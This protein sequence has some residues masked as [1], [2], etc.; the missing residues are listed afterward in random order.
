MLAGVK[1]ETTIASPASSSTW[2]LSWPGSELAQGAYTSDIVITAND[3]KGKTDS[4][5]Y[6]GDIIVDK[7]SPVI[8]ITGI[9]GN[10]TYQ[11][12]ATPIFS[13]SDS[14][15][16]ASGV[17]STTA[18]LNGAAYTSG[19]KITAGGNKTLVV[20]SKDNAGNQSQQTINF[21]I[22]KIPDV[23]VNSPIQNEIYSEFDSSFI[24]T[25]SVSDE[26]NN[27]LTC[28]YYIDSETTPRDTKTLSETI[29]KKT[30]AFNSI[31]MGSLSEGAHKIKFEIYDGSYTKQSIIDF[32]IDK[33]APVIGTVTIVSNISSISISGSATDNMPE[34]NA[35]PY[36][37]TVGDNSPSQWTA[38]T[39]YTQQSL[40]PGKAYTVKFEARDKV[41]HIASISKNTYTKAEIPR[42]EILIKSSYTL[43]VRTT[44]N[45][46]SS[47][48]YQI[49]TGSKYVTPEGTLTSSP[50]WTSL[51]NK[52]IT[53]TGLNPNTTYTFQARAKNGENVETT[54]SS[55]AS[56]TTLVAPPGSPDNIT[57]TAT[58]TS[59]TVTWDAVADATSYDIELDGAVINNGMLTAYTHSGLNP[60]TQHTYRIR[61]N[62]AGGPGNWSAP[63]TKSTTPNSSYVPLNI[64]TAATSTSVIV[65]WDAAAGATGYDIEVDGIIINNGSSTNYVHNGLISG[66]THSYRVRSINAGGKS[67]WSNE[68]LVTTL[69]GTLEVPTNL[70]AQAGKNQI[71]L[72]WEQIPGVTYEVEADGLY[73]DNGTAAS[74]THTGLTPN[75]HHSYR[76]RSKRSGATSEWSS[77]LTVTTLLD[78]FGTPT[79]LKGEA[80]NTYITLSW[81]PVKDA[82]GYDVEIDGLLIDNG[83]DTSCEHNGLSPSTR[84][85]YRVRA[86]SSETVSDWT[87]ILTLLTYLLPSPINFTC[88]STE[89]S[90][91]TVW[92]AVYGAQGYD[93]LIDSIQMISIDDNTYYEYGGLRPNTQHSF[94][95]RASNQDG[96]SAWTMPLLGATLTKSYGNNVSISGLSRNTSIVIMWNSIEGAISYDLEIDGTIYDGLTETCYFHEGLSPS[97]QYSYRIRAI[98]SAGSGDWSTLLAASTLSYGPVVPTNITLSSTKNSVRITWDN[99]DDAAEYE[100]ELDGNVISAGT[101]TSYLHSGLISNT[102]H[103]YRVRAKNLTDISPWSDVAAISTKSSEQTYTLDCTTDEVFNFI[104]TAQNIENINQSTFTITFSTSQLEMVDL[105][106][107]TSRVDT[108]VGS[109]IGTDIQVIQ[110]S[111]GTIV[112]TKRCDVPAGQSWSGVVNS[113]KFKAKVTGQVNIT[114]SIN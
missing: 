68:V 35:S 31:N 5:N 41:G 10:A 12:S 71:T 34:T 30:V 6:S 67:D 50:V 84:H 42:L 76:V 86:R 56:G 82:T 106:S 104:I 97:T 109:I 90:I 37:Y 20:T 26:D 89:T 88:T 108:T 103:T 33:T 17:V 77:M 78:E 110:C 94:K 57:A 13:A 112:L 4:K 44:D 66:T 73:V 21:V 65:T 62:N 47:T 27:N 58:N 69:V 85:S 14:H 25:V 96:T 64:N 105:C 54:L 95:V 72:S 107:T 32:K 11:D 15:T 29:N 2:T 49:T 18:T 91:T 92:E 39:S 22:N 74:Y 79:N 1:K 75:T 81:D 48:L 52:E 53:I 7:T 40:T 59:I 98:T 28:K 8:S 87:D 45:N 63:I 19:T 43:Q 113:I 38:N 83:L 23:V 9:T 3:G 55:P 61:A 114:Y 24:P 70:S 16:G 100:I 80:S 60:G 99:V 111:D 51:T 102:Q 101:G 36:R 93:L 46:S